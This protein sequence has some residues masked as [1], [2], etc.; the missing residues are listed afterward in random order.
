[1]DTFYPNE[2]EIELV[3]ALRLPR[4]RMIFKIAIFLYETWNLKKVPEV[5]YAPCFYPTGWKLTLFSLYGQR[6]PR[7]GPILKITIFGHEIWNLKKVPEV[8][9]GP[10]ST[11]G[12]RN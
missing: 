1:M 7:Y 8:A 12:G 3:F 11:P 9:Y 2:V 5:A 4:Y 6:F 10:L